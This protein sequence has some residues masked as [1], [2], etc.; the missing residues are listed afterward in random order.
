MRF[1]VNKIPAF[2][3]VLRAYRLRWTWY[4]KIGAFVRISPVAD[5]FLIETART[6]KALSEGAAKAE[7]CCGYPREVLDACWP[8]QRIDIQSWE[9]YTTWL[10]NDK[11]EVVRDAN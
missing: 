11:G 10:V 6:F 3:T 7:H 2:G 5:D 9:D 4:G 8:L 1:E